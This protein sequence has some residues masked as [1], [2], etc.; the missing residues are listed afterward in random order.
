[1]KSMKKNLEAEA[2]KAGA[3]TAKANKILKKF[4]DL[5]KNT[6]GAVASSAKKM[7]QE[8]IKQEIKASTE[9]RD[10]QNAAKKI[11]KTIKEMHRAAASKAVH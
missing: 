3:V 8:L 10:A 6:H 2:K 11:N 9:A 4:V 1:M 7:K 5:K